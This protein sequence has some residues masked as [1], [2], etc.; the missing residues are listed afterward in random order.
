MDHSVHNKLVS[1]IWSIADDCLR[2]VYVRGK[3]RDVILPM[4]VLRRLDTLLEPSKEAVLEEV[5][6]QVEE[7]NETELDDAPLCAASGYVFYNTS[8]WTLQTLFNT[9][10][11]NQQILL[12]NFEDYLNG[13]SDNVKEIVEC[14][15]LKAQIRHMAGKDVLLDVVEKFVSP[16]IN[17]TPKVKEDPE[18]NKLPALSNL[19]MGY[20]FEELIRKFNE[21]NNEEAGEHFTPREVI[22]L[23][24]H[25]VFDPI[26]DNLP[27]SIT[28]Y[29]PA[30]GSGGMLTET[31]N[32]VEEKYSASNRDIYLYGKEINDETYAICKSDMMI[33]GNNP[34]NIRVG[35]T[36][37]TDEFSSER[38]DFMLSN[39]PYGKSW[40]S[41]QKHI[42]EGKEVVDGRFK[43]KLKDY[44]GV[45][46]EQDATPRSSDGQLLFLMEMVTKMKSPQVSPLGAR[47][48]SVHNGSSLFTG[49]AG[50]GESNIRRFIIENDMLD[51]IVQLPNNLF[52]NTGIT[53][54]IWLLNNNKPETRQGKVQL[55]D[56]SLLFRKLR[57]NL[58]N[59][60]CEFS[61]EHIAE[62]VSTYLDNQTVERAID[63]KGD[64]VGIAAQVFKNQDF[65]YHKVNIERPDRRSAQFRADLIE[66]L[67]YEKSLREVMEYLYA[68]YN[69]QV[70]DAGFV[71]GIEKE[72]TK[73]CEENDISLNKAA[74]TK[75]LD[76]KNWIKQRTL[77]NAASQLHSKIGD[78]VYNDFNKFKQLVDAEL[79]SLGLK[80]AA[81]EKK[82]IVDAV[83]WYDENA[84][85]VIKKVAKLKQDKLDD[86][87]ENYECELQDL[88]DFGYYPTG[89]HNEFV[90]YE[91]SSDLRDS[92]SVP[93]EQSIYQYFLDEVKPHVDEAWV[94]LESVK[95]GY[96]ISF[97]K[98]FYRHKPLRSIDKVAQDIIALEQ[99][100][101]GLIADIL[102]ISVAKVQG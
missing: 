77:V 94:N 80:L 29:D 86:L 13:F 69:E 27:L 81:T 63:E 20:V 65:G 41:E 98:H 7:M 73:W 102:G 5:K 75:L 58:G 9:A 18:G 91:S 55:I 54:Y 34:E 56:A 3:Y 30:C 95:I 50:S 1:F 93:L 6:F 8:K 19:G 25:L 70:Y 37:S 12:A 85:K 96:E 4:V 32:F 11:N 100:A 66:P 88:P 89:N 24:T 44:W 61:P 47:I 68:E 36:L 33:K 92:E 15:N 43:V 53:T 14:F 45:E 42:K 78:E 49:D 10:T 38:F 46:S 2:D 87:L 16:Y 72:I 26:K 84:E 82:A 40:A 51:A 74:K 101:E 59:K 39:P 17:L 60:N 79:K 62:I 23:M 57:K 48:A 52:Y 97:N 21:E 67:R 22:E 76:T 64:S 83:S 31:Q 99:K 71:K 28:V 90:T 35:S